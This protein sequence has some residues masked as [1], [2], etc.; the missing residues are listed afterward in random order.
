MQKKTIHKTSL[1]L[2]SICWL[3]SCSSGKL[4]KTFEWTA[5]D[6]APLHFP[7]RIYFGS[8]HY[9]K[10]NGTSVPSGK[11]ISYGWG[12]SGTA[13]AS[14]SL[15]EVPHRL[16]ISYM[17]F[18]ENKYYG[19]SFE[20]PKAKMEQLLEQGFISID[21]LTKK[22]I[23]RN[24]T[25]IVVG[26]A[27]GGYVGIW[28]NGYNNSIQI[29]GFYA[30]ETEIDFERLVPN[31]ITDRELYVSNRVREVDAIEREKPIPFGLWETY[32]KT[33]TWQPSIKGNI[34]KDVFLLNSK[35]Y[36]GNQEFLF[37]SD[38]LKMDFKPRTIPKYISIN[39][40]RQDGFRLKSNFYIDEK[41][42]FESFKT[43]IVDPEKDT[44]TL[45]FNFNATKDVDVFLKVGNTQKQLENITL[46]TYKSA[47]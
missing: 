46:E 29:A 34:V 39:W 44:A 9:G 10:K 41:E 15:K 7:A 26:V 27:P 33:F 20:L 21:A 47:L 14:R 38:I 31:G 32:A 35:Y 16:D 8:L 40:E 1:L 2:L 6:C 23:K 12:R 36:N 5:T 18:R 25:E 43:L 19:G 28:L 45:V 24:Y 11:T 22:E 37:K 30:E 42:I 3:L 13:Y 17:S 4:S